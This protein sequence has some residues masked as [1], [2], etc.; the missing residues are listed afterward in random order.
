MCSHTLYQ[1]YKQQRRKKNAHY[2]IVSRLSSQQPSTTENVAVFIWDSLRSHM[3]NP[4]LLYEVK[5]YETDKNV[6]VY[7]GRKT[8]SMQPRKVCADC[9]SSDS[10]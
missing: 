1:I 6:V 8:A 10:D 5:L 7:R 9:I 3:P 4:D 2:L